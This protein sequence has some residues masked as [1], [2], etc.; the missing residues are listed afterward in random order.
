MTARDPGLAKSMPERASGLWWQRATGYQIWPRSFCDSNGDGIGDIPGII[1]KLDHL[2]DLGIGFVWLSPIYASPMVDMGYDIADY[3]AI[4]PEFGTLNDFDRLIEEARRRGIG[5]VM[6]LVV[7][8]SSDQ[9][10]WFRRAAADRA[11]PEH[12]YYIW[13]DPGPNG[14]PPDSRRAAFGGPAW[15]WVEAVGRYYLGYFSAEQPDLNWQNPRLRR[16]IHEMMNWWLDRGIAGFRM[17]VINLI[18]KDPDNGIFEEGPDLHPFLQ[19]MHN[20]TFVGRDVVTVG[21][22]WSATTDNALLYCGR[23]RGELSMVFQFNH[24][25][26]FEDAD[27]GKWKPQ[28]FDLVRFKKSLFSWQ[29]ALAEDG[30]NS[31]FLSNHDLPRQVSRYGDDGRWRKR[32][33]KMLATVVHLMRGTPFVYQG[34]EIGM[35]NV[36]FE[37]LDQFRD[38]EVLGNSRDWLAA[39]RT[40]AEIVAGVRSCSRDNART[41]VQ[42]SD[43][44]HGGFTAGTPWIAVNDNY[45]QINAETDRTDPVGVFA[46]YQR[47]IALRR[48]LE[49]VSHG[50]FIAHA[51]DH[52]AIVAY[53]REVGTQRLSVVANFTAGEVTL[54]VPVGLA[55]GGEA[56]IHNVTPRDAI[57]G[58]ITLAPYEAFA[59]LGQRAAQ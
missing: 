47:L 59:V 53:S 42:W 22:A 17:D 58:E 48:D 31:L 28:P 57:G 7:N 29:E 13:R 25:T 55:V 32:S 56:V 36:G 33:A 11:A 15:N 10:A 44:P 46:H 8:H 2:A 23:D 49:I 1:S 50:R 19:E 21:E 43:A 24:V 41:P 20:A 30:W 27:E 6:D 26:V 39:G 16:E 52:P 12:E 14:A 3:C 5:I 51:E 4:A 45:R 34:E 38:V 18:G 37:R 54:A 40:E 9:H 35:T